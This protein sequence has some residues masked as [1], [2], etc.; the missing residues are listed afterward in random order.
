MA[1]PHK[2]QLA[3]IR[4]S[5]SGIFWV[6]ANHMIFNFGHP[7]ECTVRYVDSKSRVGVV[8]VIFD[9][10]KLTWIHTNELYGKLVAEHPGIPFTL[11]FIIPRNP[12]EIHIQQAMAA[13]GAKTKKGTQKAKFETDS[14]EHIKRWAGDASALKKNQSVVQ[15]KDDDFPDVDGSDD[16]TIKF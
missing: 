4:H 12:L 7:S 11:G 3:T 1:V 13:I 15:F 6:R 14:G 2:K 10:V 8:T 16:L 5:S 9:G